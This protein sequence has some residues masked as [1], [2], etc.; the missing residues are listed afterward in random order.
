[1]KELAACAFRAA[2]KLGENVLVFDKGGPK[3]KKKKILA[4]FYLLFAETV[5]RERAVLPVVVGATALAFAKNELLH[6]Y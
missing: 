5:R 2:A 1:M 4:Q 3:L 6:M